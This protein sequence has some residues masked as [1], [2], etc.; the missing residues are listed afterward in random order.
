MGAPSTW[1]NRNG[2]TRVD[3]P[4]RWWAFC[5]FIPHVGWNRIR[6]QRPTL[7]MKG[8]IITSLIGNVGGRNAASFTSTGVLGGLGVMAHPL[9]FRFTQ[10]V[11]LLKG[12]LTWGSAAQ[13]PLFLLGHAH[14]EHAI[15][16]SQHQLKNPTHGGVSIAP[17]EIAESRVAK[18]LRA[19]HFWIHSSADGD[20]SGGAAMCPCSIVSFG[21]LRR[22]I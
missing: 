22:M 9:E 15:R 12:W 11:S 5:Q 1:A 6:I 14:T 10:V 21:P 13:R 7:E 2:L 20:V 18:P 4:G 17:F 19:H 16:P 8:D 3:V